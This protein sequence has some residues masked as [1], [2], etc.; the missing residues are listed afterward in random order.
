MARESRSS[1]GDPH[2]I[3]QTSFHRGSHCAA[4]HPKLPSQ[5]ACARR[6]LKRRY[7]PA[8]SDSLRSPG[9][10]PPATGNR[11]LHPAESLQ[12]ASTSDPA[13][14]PLQ[15][16]RPGSQ[17]SA[18]LHSSRYRGRPLSRLWP[19]RTKS[20]FGPTRDSPDT[21]S[22][23]CCMFT[24]VCRKRRRIPERINGFSQVRPCW[25]C[26]DKATFAPRARYQWWCCAPPCQQVRR[27]LKIA[28][29]RSNQG[30]RPHRSYHCLRF[31]D[32]GLEGVAP[33]NRDLR[34]KACSHI[35]RTASGTRPF[36]SLPPAAARLSR[37]Q[38]AMVAGKPVGPGRRRG[39]FARP[40]QTGS[41]AGGFRTLLCAPRAGEPGSL[42]QLRTRARFNN[43]Y[44]RLWK[45]LWQR[46]MRGLS[47]C[48][49]SSSSRGVHKRATTALTGHC[50]LC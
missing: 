3:A 11:A 9:Q 33:Y 24:F 39:I 16:H 5:S 28:E 14:K 15:A 29:E 38:S 48:M 31:P 30:I 46:T 42:D 36:L 49:V 18:S 27:L 37:G 22:T 44:R 43:S 10:H 6:L 25:R 12:A 32:F 19:Q 4:P 45:D 1:G 13:R 7:Q 23:P 21:Q 47:A 40:G 50:E 34:V 41:L 35:C 8:S 26:L 20:L 17:A 2:R